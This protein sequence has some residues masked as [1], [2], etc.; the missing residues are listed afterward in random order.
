[1]NSL[2]W[3]CFFK[4]VFLFLNFVIVEI[5]FIIFIKSSL[6][7]SFKI[8]LIFHH[9]ILSLVWIY[10]RRFAHDSMFIPKLY[11]L[12]LFTNLFHCRSVF[13]IFYFHISFKKFFIVVLFLYFSTI[14]PLFYCLAFLSTLANLLMHFFV[15][16]YFY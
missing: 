14:F 9:L 7:R 16:V 11:L 8:H 15:L 6:F 1:M 13:Y 10:F 12:Y 5:I 2:F 4:F 3:N